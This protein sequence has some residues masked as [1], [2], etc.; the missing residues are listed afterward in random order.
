MSST[1]DETITEGPWP[2]HASDQAGAANRRMC[3]GVYL[4]SDFRDLVLRSI[5][6]GRNRRVAP[7]YGFSLIPV[8]VHAWR[9]WRLEVA[10]HVLILAIFVTAGVRVWR[11]AAI[12]A[13][14]LAAAYVGRRLFPLIGEIA[15]FYRGRGSY[16]ELEGLRKRQ[17][18]L[19]YAMLLFLECVRSWLSVGFKPAC[20]GTGRRDSCWPAVGSLAAR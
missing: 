13:T 3:A 10:Q 4:D 2:Y 1:L 9:A 16:L 6:C 20:P 19:G 11:A 18:P 12:A 8:T 5:Y 17:E 7:S 14:I 15:A